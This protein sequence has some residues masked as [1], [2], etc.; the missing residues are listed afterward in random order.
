MG[1]YNTG[2]KREHFSDRQAEVFAIYKRLHEANL[3]KM[4]P[5]PV[6]EIPE[7]FR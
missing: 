2:K 3:H 1:A 7:V 4:N 6:C 5:I